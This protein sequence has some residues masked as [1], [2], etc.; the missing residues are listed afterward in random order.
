[1]ADT[2][3]RPARAHR[4][5]R[6]LGNRLLDII[7]CRGR[8]RSSVTNDTEIVVSEEIFITPQEEKAHTPD[9]P[10]YSG[11]PQV[12]ND[13][14]PN[15]KPGDATQD[16]QVRHASAGGLQKIEAGSTLA[17]ASCSKV[18]GEPFPPDDELD[19]H[20]QVKESVGEISHVM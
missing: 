10:F 8:G 16:I 15:V 4:G 20:S 13:A 1:M 11:S 14:Q 5:R 18:P 9:V 12:V 19:S 7:T 17:A 2:I 3:Q 6:S